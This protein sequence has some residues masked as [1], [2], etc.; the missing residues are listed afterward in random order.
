MNDLQ[1]VIERC[2][3]IHSQLVDLNTF[4]ATKDEKIYKDASKRIE[5]MMLKLWKIKTDF[6]FE[7][8]PDFYLPK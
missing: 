8:N 4:V 1:F 3:E 7:Q 5:K 2:D 6:K